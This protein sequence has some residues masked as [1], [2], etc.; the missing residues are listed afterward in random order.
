M[1]FSI[2]VLLLFDGYPQEVKSGGINSWRGSFKGG[3]SRFLFQ[4]LRDPGLFHGCSSMTSQDRF[5]STPESGVKA[6]AT[7]GDHSALLLAYGLASLH[8]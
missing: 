7:R 8:E 2:A 3:V 5:D 6:D 4:V 1:I